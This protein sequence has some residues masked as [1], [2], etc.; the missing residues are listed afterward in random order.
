MILRIC[1][2]CTDS[3]FRTYTEDYSD[4]SDIARD[5]ERIL[6]DMRRKPW[7]GMSTRE[8]AVQFSDSLAKLWRVHPFREG[9]TRTILTFCCQYADEVGLTPDRSLFEDHAAY[10]RTALVAY[11]AVFDD[12]GDV[13]KPEYLIR[14][15]EDA[16]YRARGRPRRPK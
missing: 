15:V 6:A 10:V 11:N 13:S 9:N 2:K 14:I 3:S 8:A 12:I 7:N 4:A 1:C 5:S 16:L